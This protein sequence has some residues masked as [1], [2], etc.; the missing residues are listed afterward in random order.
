MV[1]TANAP[2]SGL[3]TKKR[4]DTVDQAGKTSEEH[5]P[6]K[7]ECCT[8]MLKIALTY[9]AR[10]LCERVAEMSHRGDLNNRYLN[11]RVVKLAR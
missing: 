7:S 4:E 2:A 9:G 10:M 3:C 8:H 11:H 6:A 5:R 1:E